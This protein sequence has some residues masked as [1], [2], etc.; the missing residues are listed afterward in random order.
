MVQLEYTQEY[1]RCTHTVSAHN[2]IILL[3]IH[4]QTLLY[5]CG[6]CRSHCHVGTD[7]VHREESDELMHALRVV[8][9]GQW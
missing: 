1:T 8:Q 6:I 2:Y 7:G 9:S 4:T 3:Y 5:T